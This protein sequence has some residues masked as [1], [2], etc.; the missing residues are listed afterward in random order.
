M[1]IGRCVAIALTAALAAC[2]GAHEPQPAPSRAPQA[3]RVVALA[4]YGRR[5][6]TDTPGTMKAF[7]TADMSCQACHVNAG[8]KPRGGSFI[9]IYAQFPQWNK[10]A[11][12][13]ISLQDRI[14]ECFLYSMNG[15]P[16]GYASLQMEA[17]VA[18]IAQL[19]RGT[20][21]GSAADPTNGLARVSAPRPPSA[22]RGR[23]VYAQRCSSCH[24][25]NGAGVSG[26]FPPLWG[27]AS[28]NDGAGMHR[29]GTMASFV[30]YNMP[31]NAPGTL[32]DEQAYDVAAFVL[33]PTRPH[34][35]KQ[36][37][38]RFPAMRANYF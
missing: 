12:R 9:G 30:R 7:V 32:T 36:L 21:V 34:F 29:V 28:F 3:S 15:R 2:A 17:I 14:A 11:H 33:S 38:V 37:I 27:A 13:V 6:V 1:Q 20:P 23:Q 24:Q 26:T 18:Y 22:S 35:D 4:A 5:I 8:T 10:R 19:S 25:A 31:A 16:P